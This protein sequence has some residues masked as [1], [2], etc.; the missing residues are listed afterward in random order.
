MCFP[1]RRQRPSPSSTPAY[2]QRPS[3]TSTCRAPVTPR[4]F[5]LSRDWCS[6]PKGRL[7]GMGRVD[8]CVS[9]RLVFASDGTGS[10]YSAA[11]TRRPRA[12]QGG[13]GEGSAHRTS[14]LA[15]GGGR[16]RNPCL[17]QEK[18]LGQG[19]GHW[20]ES[21]GSDRHRARRY[22]WACFALEQ[23]ALTDG[24]RPRISSLV[25]CRVPTWCLLS[26]SLVSCSLAG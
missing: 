21:C 4:E 11:L 15:L 24:C 19:H 26:V 12:T 23:H 22:P 25:L 3:E 5:S 20:N 16:G 17:H 9:M 7:C 1:R 14:S 13:R 2:S 10:N 18:V 6:G 8:V